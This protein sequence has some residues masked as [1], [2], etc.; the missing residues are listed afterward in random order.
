MSKR[1]NLIF[2]TGA[3]VSK[4]S[5]IPTFD[6][7]PG[8][9]DV[10]S[11]EFAESNPLAFEEACNGM[12]ASIEGAEPNAAHLAIAQYD[13]P[14]ITMNVD[15]LHQKAG[16]KQVIEMHGNFNN[17]LVLYGDK[18]DKYTEAISLVNKLQYHNSYFIIIG[19]SFYTQISNFLHQHALSRN[20]KVIIID[21]DAATEVP[22]L[23]ERISKRIKQ[24]E[25]E[26]E[27]EYGFNVFE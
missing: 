22:L 19:T 3:G 5:G 6:E 23:L 21:K 25:E 9:R 1:Y 8:I 10:L 20:A 26:E 4:E 17:G 7:M 27:N 11:R 18:A 15:G 16:S 12:K 13:V 2:F 24:K 14:V